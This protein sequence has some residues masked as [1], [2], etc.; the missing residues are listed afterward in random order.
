MSQIDYID[1]YTAMEIMSRQNTAPSE[2]LI[3]FKADGKDFIAV[4]KSV[5]GNIQKYVRPSI[6]LPDVEINVVQRDLE[7]FKLALD[8]KTAELE[9]LRKEDKFSQIEIASGFKR[10]YEN[11]VIRLT[12]KLEALKAQAPGKIQKSI[13]EIKKFMALLDAE[14]K[15]CEA[16]IADAEKLKGRYA[17]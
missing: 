8:R 1:D 11:K 17:E 9:R 14:I 4:V 16:I 12:A 15:K 10:E 2:T 3:D 6:E 13:D 5:D 7:K